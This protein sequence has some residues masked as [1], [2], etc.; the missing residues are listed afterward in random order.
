MVDV[1]SSRLAGTC[2]GRL[3]RLLSVTASDCSLI[4]FFC[5]NERFSS[6]A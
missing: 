2:F 4:G 6:L 5:A 1:P 3:R